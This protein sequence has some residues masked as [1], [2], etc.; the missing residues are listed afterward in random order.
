MLK[1][2]GAISHVRVELKTKVSV[3]SVS[4]IG[5]DVTR[6]IAQENVSACQISLIVLTLGRR[7][8]LRT[9][10]FVEFY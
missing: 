8:I 9:S 7:Q 6:L 2:S 5:V 3:I 4:I 1:F 10:W